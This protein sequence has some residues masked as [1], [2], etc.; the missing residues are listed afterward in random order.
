MIKLKLLQPEENLFNE[1]TCTVIKRI[2]MYKICFCPH[3]QRKCISLLQ[4]DIRTVSL[5]CLSTICQSWEWRIVSFL[6]L[7]P[8][9]IFRA[10][11]NCF[12]HFVC[13]FFQTFL[14][15][16]SIICINKICYYYFF[17]VV[18]YEKPKEILTLEQEL[19]KEL[20]KLKGSADGDVDCKTQ[21]I[22]PVGARE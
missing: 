11:N 15:R 13:S 12:N 9:F 21:W 1:Y 7:F 20:K 8:T 4:R 16:H 6:F 17:S 22:L 10:H 3:I 5:Y 18:Q 19:L 2:Y 14:W